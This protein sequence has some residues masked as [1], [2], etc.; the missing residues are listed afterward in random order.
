MGEVVLANLP[1][2]FREAVLDVEAGGIAPVIREERGFRIVKVLDRAEEREYTFEE[3]REE[4]KGLIERRKLQERMADYIDGL[5]E[6]Y[7]VEIKGES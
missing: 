3:A 5:K 2:H 7:F 1:E 6:K 4:L